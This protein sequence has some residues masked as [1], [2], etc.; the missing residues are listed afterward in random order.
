[1]F[2]DVGKHR[3]VLNTKARVSHVTEDAILTDI[4]TK[5]KQPTTYMEKKD[6]RG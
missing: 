6:Y 2:K 1:M 3:L 5:V 4:L